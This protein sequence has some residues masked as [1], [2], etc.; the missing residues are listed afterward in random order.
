MGLQPEEAQ[1]SL[2]F[3]FGWDTT[4]AD[5]DAAAEIVIGACENRR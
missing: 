5:A 3:T 2:R 1:R 4:A